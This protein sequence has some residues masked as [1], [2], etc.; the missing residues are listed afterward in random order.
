MPPYAAFHQGLHCLPKYSS[1]CF[2]YKKG[3]LIQYC[4]FIYIVIHA[5]VHVHVVPITY[6]LCVWVSLSHFAGPRS[7]VG[8]CNVSGYRCMSSCRS[9]GREFDPD[10]VS[11]FSGDL[12]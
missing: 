5:A 9:R 10:A 11:Y 12:S 2:Q 8:T 6:V 1:R 4:V 3:I 7:A